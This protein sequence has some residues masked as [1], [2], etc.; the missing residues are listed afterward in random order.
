[1]F[2]KPDHSF[3][4]VVQYYITRDVRHKLYHVAADLNVSI[5]FKKAESLCSKASLRNRMVTTVRCDE[6]DYIMHIAISSVSS[7]S[8]S[9]STSWGGYDAEYRDSCVC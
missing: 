7:A 1:M 6:V 3:T 2:D 5:C 9:S 8:S 4:T